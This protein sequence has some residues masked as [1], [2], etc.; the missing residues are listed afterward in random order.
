MRRYIILDRDGVINH[1]SD[2]FIKSSD[3]WQPIDGSLE[4]IALLN[5]HQYHV[6][7]ITNQSG[8]A[9][10]LFSLET[11]NSIHDKMLAA[12]HN[13]GG[14]I[15]AIY[16]CPHGPE[17]GCFCRKPKPGLLK[18]F[19]EE[20]GAELSGLPVI[21][22]SMRDLQAA[23]AVNAHPILVRTGKG[24]RIAPLTAKTNIPIYENLYEAS[25]ALVKSKLHY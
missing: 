22:D 19:S 20:H 21:G 18:Q 7:V 2:D 17:D 13:T 9:R 24:E 6:V 12:I 25:I 15:H 10:Q 1:D 4:A 3:E 14:A 16:F 23:T 5:Q 11:L 8:I